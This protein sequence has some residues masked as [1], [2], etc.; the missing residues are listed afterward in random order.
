MIAEISAWCA[1]QLQPEDLTYIRTFARRWSS[2]FRT[3]ALC[4]VFMGR[5]RSYDDIIVA[6]APDEELERLLA[7]AHAT[8]LAGGH[9]HVPLLRR[10]RDRLL[11][12]PGSVGLPFEVEARSD[13]VR[14]PPWAE[15]GLIDASVGNPS[16]EFRRVP[17]EVRTIVDAVFESGM[18]HATVLAQDWG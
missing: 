11:V 3:E 4:S 16:V 18:P 9:T 2:P 12:K 8:I 1:A 10:H 5:P 15:Y 14:N 7:G 6:N 13:R 17:V